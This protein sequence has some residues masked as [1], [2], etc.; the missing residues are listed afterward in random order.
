M[1]LVSKDNG[2][3]RC[4][5]PFKSICVFSY[6]YKDMGHGIQNKHVSII[7]LFPGDGGELTNDGLPFSF[8][9]EELGRFGSFNVR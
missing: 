3:L 5:K 2:Y 8:H 6:P 7:E 1:P 4:L 9:D